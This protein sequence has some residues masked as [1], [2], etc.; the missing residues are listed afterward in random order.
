M[1]TQARASVSSSSSLGTTCVL[2]TSGSSS[3]TAT[4]TEISPRRILSAIGSIAR[5]MLRVSMSPAASRPALS[6]LC[7]PQAGKVVVVRSQRV[8][9]RAAPLGQR[10]ISALSKPGIDELDSSSSSRFVTHRAPRFGSQS[11]EK[12]GARDF[13]SVPARRPTGRHVGEGRGPPGPP[14]QPRT[15]RAFVRP[16]SGPRTVGKPHRAA[17]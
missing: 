15:G 6:W 11:G 17:R 13:G 3:A 8:P 2:K 1:L 4:N 12:I 16:I 5:R 14:H 7:F 9:S 10:E